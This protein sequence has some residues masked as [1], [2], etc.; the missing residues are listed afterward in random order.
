MNLYSVDTTEWPESAH[1]RAFAGAS[2]WRVSA[3]PPIAIHCLRMRAHVGVANAV[4][5]PRSLLFARQKGSSLN[6]SPQSALRNLAVELTVGRD[7]RG[8][9]PSVFDFRE[10]HL[11]AVQNRLKFL[12]Q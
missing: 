2:R 7:T 3:T 6:R 4:P 8:F 5:L 9:T 12:G 11:C 10:H 1:P